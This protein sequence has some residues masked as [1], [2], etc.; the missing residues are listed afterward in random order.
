M[1]NR[2]VILS[3]AAIFIAIAGAFTTNANGKKIALVQYYEKL[4]ANASCV[5]SSCTT[6]LPIVCTGATFYEQSGSM[7][8]G[9]VV[10][11]TRN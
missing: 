2:S 10:S 11:L 3:L 6:G 4:N 5:T 9:N 8:C 1:K 7:N